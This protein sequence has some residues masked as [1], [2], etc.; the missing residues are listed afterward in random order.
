MKNSE[1]RE[2][3]EIQFYH[4]I[5][6]PKAN[7]DSRTAQFIVVNYFVKM[8]ILEFFTLIN[9]SAIHFS[10][11]DLQVN[12]KRQL[13]VDVDFENKIRKRLIDKKIAF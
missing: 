3:L 13:Q 12:N 10:D 1:Y 9:N 2:E 11:S 4:R 8:T 6:Y 7:L 5:N